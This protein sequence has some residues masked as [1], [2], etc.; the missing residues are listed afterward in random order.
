MGVDKEWRRK[1]FILVGEIAG[2]A[3]GEKLLIAPWIYASCMPIIHSSI[4][5][6]EVDDESG[7]ATVTSA[8]AFFAAH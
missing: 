1:A 2:G 7:A 8:I 3:T 6:M 5:I 4:P